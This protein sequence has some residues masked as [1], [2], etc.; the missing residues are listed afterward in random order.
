MNI[1]V[2]DINPFKAAKNLCNAHVIKMIVES[3]QLLS[4]HDR[5]NGLEESRYKITHVNHPCRRCLENYSNY[6]W[7]QYHLYG[8]LKEYTYR[9]KKIHKCQELYEKY[10]KRND[11]E[12]LYF[13]KIDF[14]ENYSELI[15]ATAF[16]QC[17]PIQFKNNS[18]DIFNVVKAYRNYYL[19]KKEVLERWKYTNSKEPYWI[20]QNA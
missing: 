10:W 20:N 9:Y 15:D 19:F 6:V 5:L 4:T 18:T 16:P 2:T 7:L 8:L 3:C 13:K 11:D 17:M 1:F 14:I 12:D